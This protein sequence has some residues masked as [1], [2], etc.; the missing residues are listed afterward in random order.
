MAKLG[1]EYRTPDFC[2]MR[3]KVFLLLIVSSKGYIIHSVRC[4]AFESLAKGKKKLHIYILRQKD[5]CFTL[6]YGPF[7]KINSIFAAGGWVEDSVLLEPHSMNLKQD[8]SSDCLKMF[9]SIGFHMEKSMR[10]V[11][12]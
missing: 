3:V 4:L 6:I 5:I 1:L 9:F 10:N 12:G 8:I 2:L 11:Q 7:A